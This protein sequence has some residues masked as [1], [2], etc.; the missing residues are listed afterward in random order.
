MYQFAQS[1][2]PVLWFNGLPLE[3]QHF[4][5]NDM[6]YQSLLFKMQYYFHPFSWGIIDNLVLP[7]NLINAKNLKGE[8]IYIQK[9]KFLFKDLSFVCY[10][11]DDLD[12]LKVSNSIIA[13]SLHINNE[14][15]QKIKQ[16][17][18]NSVLIYIALKQ[19]LK[20]DK[21]VTE[22][23]NVHS[24][25]VVNTKYITLNDTKKSND[26]YKDIHLSGGF[27]KEVQKLYYSLVILDEI[28]LNKADSLYTED[29]CLP[30]LRVKRTKNDDIILDK[31]YIPATISIKNSANLYK[32]VNSIKNNIESKNKELEPLK[33]ESGI[34][35][36]DFNSK[37]IN[38]FLYLK[39]TN[40]I[41]AKLSHIFHL[42]DTHKVPVHPLVLFQ[43]F[44]EFIGEMSTFTNSITAIGL[45]DTKNP[46]YNL[47]FYD[48]NRLDECFSSAKNI[49][50]KMLSGDYLP[51]KIIRMKRVADIKKDIS[52]TDNNLFETIQEIN[53]SIFI[54]TDPVESNL[55]KEKIVMLEIVTTV[56]TL[57]QE[58]AENHLIVSSLSDISDILR[59]TEKG[60]TLIFDHKK[61]VAKPLFTHLYQIEDTANL[62]KENHVGF[63]WRGLPKDSVQISLIIK[64]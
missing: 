43:M 15:I 20:N 9:G 64:G 52:K 59:K 21:N 28:E 3:P 5:Q 25:T 56:E 39:A 37:S 27:P 47:L 62:S 33:K 2:L 6:F 32:I 4:Q 61:T 34:D 49:I 35:D 7:E 29:E 45:Q 36:V 41:Y 63:F 1:N 50:S 46:A 22:I 55:F 30:I 48:H 60:L 53:D 40:K 17:D 13:K 14:W 38:F 54:N 11:K 19:F 10:D 24:R 31:S 26:E 18:R 44:V 42:I 58:K 8:A 16:L 51:G 23:Q 57:P 12:K